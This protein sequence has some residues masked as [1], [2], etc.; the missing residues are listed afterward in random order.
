MT[1]TH[2]ELSSES[3]AYQKPRITPY[4]SHRAIP[5]ILPFHYTN[6]NVP[7]PRFVSYRHSKPLGACPPSVVRFVGFGLSL[8]V[9]HAHVSPPF[10]RGR[11]IT[12]VPLLDF[13]QRHVTK[14]VNHLTED[15][16][17]KGAGSWVTMHSGRRLLDFTSG[18]GVTSLGTSGRTFFLF[19]ADLK[20]IRSLPS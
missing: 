1:D 17:V 3:P 13:A 14:G 2:N 18:I 10:S 15:V 5:P 6:D 12:T 16:F 7:W 20:E 8:V 11:P 4:H 9:S 19:N